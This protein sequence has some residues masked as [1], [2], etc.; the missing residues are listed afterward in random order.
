MSFAVYSYN[1]NLTIGWALASAASSLPCNLPPYALY[2]QLSFRK[3]SS[4]IYMYCLV[5]NLDSQLWIN[6]TR[7]YIWEFYSQANCLLLS[8]SALWHMSN[9]ISLYYLIECTVQ[10]SSS[11]LHHTLPHTLSIHH[12]GLYCAESCFLLVNY[13]RNARAC[14]PGMLVYERCRS[15]IS[16]LISFIASLHSN[17]I[18]NF[19]IALHSR[20]VIFNLCHLSCFHLNFKLQYKC[21]S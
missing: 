1:L 14:V 21:K 13:R 18:E 7:F 11:D 8:T 19:L 12:S 2:L 4:K 3:F 5:H 10:M 6:S 9:Y 17:L 15:E 20:L 16:I